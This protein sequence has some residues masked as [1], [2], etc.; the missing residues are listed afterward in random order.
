MFTGN[1][2]SMLKLCGS[3]TQCAI[4]KS[5][6]TTT[7]K[8]TIH[9]FIFISSVCNHTQYNQPHPHIHHVPSNMSKK[10]FSLGE[11]IAALSDPRPQNTDPEDAER[12]LNA[13]KV[14]PYSYE[15]FKEDSSSTERRSSLRTQN[16]D[17]DDDPRYAGE[18]VSR[19][20]L[21][22]E[23]G[24]GNLGKNIVGKV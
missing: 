1:T 16:D 23:W 11:Q 9:L 20:I 22:E 19:K 6:L 4:E 24:V 8:L 21:E 14:C 17:W 5:Q 12:D 15:D 7:H 13:A 2:K 18:P 10:K 3:Q